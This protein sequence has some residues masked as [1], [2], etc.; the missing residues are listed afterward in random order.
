VN[1]LKRTGFPVPPDGFPA[2][3]IGDD[4]YGLY[5]L[6]LQL[7]NDGSRGIAVD[8]HNRNCGPCLAKRMG[9]GSPDPLPGPGD[10]PN[11]ASEPES[12]QNRLPGKNF[13]FRMY[14]LSLQ[15]GH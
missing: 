13:V 15:G 12:F 9:E 1:S 2:G 11:L 5:P 3:D 4:G 6:A 10:K 14:G 7:P 8:I